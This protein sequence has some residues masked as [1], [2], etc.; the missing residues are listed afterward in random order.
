MRMAKK[1]HKSIDSF[2]ESDT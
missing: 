2:M 1:N